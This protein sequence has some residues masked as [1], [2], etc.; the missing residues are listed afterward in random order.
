MQI[1]PLSPAVAKSL[2]LHVI[3]DELLFVQDIQFPL[4]YNQQWIIS[5]TFMRQKTKFPHWRMSLLGN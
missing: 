3:I 2:V 5:K 4:G 1:T